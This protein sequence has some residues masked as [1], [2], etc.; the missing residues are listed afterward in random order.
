MIFK[1]PLD[2]ENKNA[3]EFITTWLKEI[4]ALNDS[5]KVIINEIECVNPDCPGTETIISIVDEGNISKK[6]RLHKPLVFIRKVDI[7]KCFL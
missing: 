1:N 2:P 6:I 7:E 5:T 4:L 3:R